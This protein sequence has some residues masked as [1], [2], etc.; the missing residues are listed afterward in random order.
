MELLTTLWNLISNPLI[1]IV[2]TLNV[3]R[4]IVNKR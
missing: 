1:F 4:I 3:I 2:L